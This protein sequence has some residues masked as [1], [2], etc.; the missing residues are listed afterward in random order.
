MGRYFVRIPSDGT[1]STFVTKGDIR[2]GC[3]YGA[4]HTTFPERNLV[5]HRHAG[6]H[7]CPDRDALPRRDNDRPNGNPVMEACLAAGGL[8]HLWR[9]DLRS[10]MPAGYRQPL[11]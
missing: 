8:A 1:A 4:D 7:Y 9:Y 11:L 2:A 3:G 5:A 6:E 10:Q